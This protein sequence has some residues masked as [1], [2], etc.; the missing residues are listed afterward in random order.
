[1]KLIKKDKLNYSLCDTVA[2]LSMLGAF[3]LVEDAMCQMMGELKLDGETCIREYDGMWVFVKN[4]IEL[5]RKIH[6][7]DEYTI[8][9]YITNAGGVKLIVDTLIKTKGNIAVASRAELCAIDHKTGRI[10]R[11]NTV[12]LNETICGE[13]AEIDIG[14]HNA[15]FTPCELVDS[16]V[17]R[18]SDIDF[19][20]HTNNVSYVR[21]LLNQYD[22]A[23]LRRAP[24]SVLEIRY[25]NQTFEG[26]TLEIYKCQDDN[27]T[28][29]NNGKAVVNCIILQ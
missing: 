14:F 19:Y 7:M 29:L 26:D 22:T 8:E 28:I 23:E 17:V 9:C 1:M 15:D 11:G 6:W 13:T 25:V 4:R 21:Y 5:R 20:H 18:S 12:G 2:N 27:F 16:V 3:Q 10:R 24:I